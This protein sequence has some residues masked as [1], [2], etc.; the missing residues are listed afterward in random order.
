MVPMREDRIE[1]ALVCERLNCIASAKKAL[2]LEV[3][4]EP[5]EGFGAVSQYLKTDAVVGFTYFGTAFD[6]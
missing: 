2:R 5:K 4:S 3:Y 6:S 1:V